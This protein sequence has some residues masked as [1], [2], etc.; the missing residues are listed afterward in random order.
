MPTPVDFIDL[1]ADT[2]MEDVDDSVS[3]R[4]ILFF[5]SF[6]LHLPYQPL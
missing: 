3:S 4:F 6:H 2:D 5:F 1:T